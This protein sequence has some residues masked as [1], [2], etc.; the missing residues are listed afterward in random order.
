MIH[1]FLYCNIEFTDGLLEQQRRYWGV[2]FAEIKENRLHLNMQPV[3]GAKGSPAFRLIT[4]DLH[5]KITSNGDIIAYLHSIRK[6]KVLGVIV[7]FLNS[8]KDGLF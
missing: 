2:V 8:Q 6:K 3:F 7:S 1:C 5:H 4:S